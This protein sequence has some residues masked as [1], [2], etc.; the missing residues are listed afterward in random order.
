[1][2]YS[3]PYLTLNQSIP[4]SNDIT[5]FVHVIR[6]GT[7]HRWDAADD[8]TRICSLASGK[9]RVKLEDQEFV[10]GSNGMV[11]I[12][13]G[14]VATVENRTYVDSVVHVTSVQY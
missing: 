14:V 7:L 12:K 2:A 8:R 10:I 1:M 9:L 13:P 5:F 11:K 4:V 6:P 3:A